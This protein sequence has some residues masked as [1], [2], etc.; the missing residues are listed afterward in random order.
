MLEEE[1]PS[2]YYELDELNK[3]S[4]AYLIIAD[5]DFS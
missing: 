4:I 3:S 5:T 1:Y 2:I